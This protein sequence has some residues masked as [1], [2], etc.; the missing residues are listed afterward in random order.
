RAAT[1]DR[2]AAASDAR[3]WCAERAWVSSSGGVGGIG[4]GYWA[5]P[6]AAGTI[7]L[8]GFGMGMFGRARII[9]RRRLVAFPPSVVEQQIQQDGH[10][11]T[12]GHT[13][14]QDRL[15]IRRELGVHPRDENRQQPEGE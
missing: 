11:R 12:H 6:I 15:H 7:G 3:A 5:S 14:A 4:C 9:V 1:P 10:H 13:A 8:G 2:A